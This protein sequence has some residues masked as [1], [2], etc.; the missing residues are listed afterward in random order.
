MVAVSA[1]TFVLGLFACLVTGFV[2]GVLVF[3]GSGES[4]TIF[5]IYEE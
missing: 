3:G 2:I 1:E 5:R 4:E